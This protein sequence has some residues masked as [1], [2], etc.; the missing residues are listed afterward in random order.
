MDACVTAMAFIVKSL[1]EQGKSFTV[2]SEHAQ[3][4]EQID[5][6]VN[7]EEDGF[8]ITYSVSV[9]NGNVFDPLLSGW[10]KFS[11]VILDKKVW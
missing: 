11:I 4:C 9:Q 3:C 5:I 1:L 8:P 6:V 7:G 2:E 10:I